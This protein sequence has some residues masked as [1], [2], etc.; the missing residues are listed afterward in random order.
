MR[1]TPFALSALIA[2]GLSTHAKAGPEPVS[3]AIAELANKCLVAV[4]GVLAKPQFYKYTAK[5]ENAGGKLNPEV[6]A[7]MEV[8]SKNA[9]YKLL[10][11]ECTK[12]DLAAA[13]KLGGSAATGDDYTRALKDLIRIGD[14]VPTYCPN[15]HHLQ[16]DCVLVPDGMKA[17]LTKMRSI[18]VDVTPKLAKLA[19]PAPTCLATTAELANKC[20]VAANGLAA[21]PVSYK[22]TPLPKNAGGKVLNPEVKAWQEAWSSNPDYK[23]LRAEC[24]KPEVAAAIKLASGQPAAD[25]W[26]AAFK[27]FSVQGNNIGAYC[28]NLHKAQ[29]DCAAAPGRIQGD[30][31]RLQK[32]LTEVNP[33]LATLCTKK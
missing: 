28:P 33:K 1:T 21:K 26:A 13:I 3:P 31:V 29:F 14:G 5:P 17:D 27:D 8:W 32:V 9:D 4:N 2:L 6:Q 11:E 24:S 23:L 25:E 12:P 18:L 30:V 19:T 10:R 20:L 16:W 15:Y 22:F 7:W